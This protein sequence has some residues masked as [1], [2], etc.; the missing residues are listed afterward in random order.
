MGEQGGSE[1]TRGRDGGPLVNVRYALTWHDAPAVDWRVR[2]FELDEALS[3]P[4]VLRMQRVT[5][6]VD[7]DVDALLGASCTLTLARTVVE[8]AVHGIVRG[9]EQLAGED[10]RL[11]VEVT[12]VPALTTR[13]A[14]SEYSRRRGAR[15][16]RAM[17]GSSSRIGTTRT[18][19]RASEA[20]R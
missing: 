18:P 20:R 5:G 8:R 4:Y 2:R 13:C 19:A 12:V 6:D 9:V 7:A 1:D 17:A 14:G 15:T 3:E 11:R 10:G 16:S